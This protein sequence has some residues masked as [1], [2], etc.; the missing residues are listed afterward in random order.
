LRGK[1]VPHLRAPGRGDM[2][3]R[4]TVVVPDDL[5]DEQRELLE[6]LALTMGTPTLPKQNKGFFERIRDA[7]AG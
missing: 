1:G 3:V 4:V 6:K 5:T 7:M 2:V